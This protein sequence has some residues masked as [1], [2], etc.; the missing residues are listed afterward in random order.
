MPDS[1]CSMLNTHYPICLVLI[2][3]S[4]KDTLFIPILQM[5]KSMFREAK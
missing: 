4:L 1:V 2:N 5:K 3:N